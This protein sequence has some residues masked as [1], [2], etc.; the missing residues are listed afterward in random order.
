MQRSYFMRYLNNLL[1]Y[2]CSRLERPF[3]YERMSRPLRIETSRWMRSAPA[4]PCPP[5]TEYLNQVLGRNYPEYPPL[6]TVNGQRHFG[7]PKCWTFSRG[8]PPGCE[9]FVGSIPRDV[10]EDVL[11]PI[12]MKIGPIYKFR[13]MLDFSGTNRGFAF[14]TFMTPEHA[15][16]AC[17]RLNGYIVSSPTLKKSRRIGVVKSIDNRKLYIGGIPINI[18]NDDLLQELQNQ[19][20]HGVHKVQFHSPRLPPG[21]VPKTKYAFVE[22]EDHY[23][24]AMARRQLLPSPAPLWGNPNIQVDWAKPIEELCPIGGQCGFQLHK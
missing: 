19:K 11:I 22:F 6:M 24:A 13:L 16:Q 14:V 20:I 8:P 9:V 2:C 18:T 3:S 15:D 7:P 23:S 10:F 1:S 4:Q 17:L 5:T 21:R 12:F